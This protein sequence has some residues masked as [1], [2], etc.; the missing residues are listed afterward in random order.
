METNISVHLHSKK[1]SHQT[2]ETAYEWEKTFASYTS[3]KGLITKI[4]RE[5]KKLTSQRINNPLNIF[6][7]SKEVQMS[8]KHMKRAG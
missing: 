1:N 7:F 8:N 2:E 4:C 6:Q 5:L 3:D